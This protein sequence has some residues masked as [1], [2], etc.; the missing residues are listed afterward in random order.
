MT[1]PNFDEVPFGTGMWDARH[2]PDN[3]DLD[4]AVREASGGTLAVFE[5]D[6]E[7]SD[8]AIVVGPSSWTDE[9]AFAAWESTIPDYAR[10][11]T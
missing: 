4:R 5:I 3:D 1:G 11:D 6:T 9:E 2:G 10:D 7:S 8:A